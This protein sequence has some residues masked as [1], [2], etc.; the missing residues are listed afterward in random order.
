M[1]KKSQI[2][3][4]EGKEKALDALFGN[5][6]ATFGYLAIGCKNETDSQNGF[7][8]PLVTQN[9]STAIGFNEIQQE[10]Y[11]RI[12]L[13]KVANGVER[14]PDSGKVLKKYQAVL[15][16]EN[17]TQSQDI[18]QIAV[19]D[20]QNTSSTTTIYSATTFQTFNKTNESSITF[21]IGFRL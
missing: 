3:F 7:E 18:N 17:I 11:H 19:V 15:D 13:Q 8:D 2:I 14:D 5:D 9:D 4:M 1:T 20:N 12:K 16:N 10:S 21:V 6:D